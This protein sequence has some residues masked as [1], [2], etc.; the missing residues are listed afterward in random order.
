[1]DFDDGFKLSAFKN[2]T[3]TL[4]FL[5]WKFNPENNKNFIKELVDENLNQLKFC[6]NWLSSF[7]IGDMMFICPLSL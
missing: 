1:M 3:N 7:N 4:K 5:E 6:T 2:K